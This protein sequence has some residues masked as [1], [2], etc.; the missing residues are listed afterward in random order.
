MTGVQ[1]FMTQQGKVFRE[2]VFEF[3]R[4][5]VYEF[6]GMQ[7]LQNLMKKFQKS[8]LNA[9][10]K[11]AGKK[12]ELFKEKRVDKWKLDAQTLKIHAVE[13]LM[14]NK[15]LAFSKMLPKVLS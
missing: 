1:E 10:K 13:S 9:E 2:N 3:F 11:L 6:E 4:Y 15:G 12:D 7:E 8:F 14:K 5:Q